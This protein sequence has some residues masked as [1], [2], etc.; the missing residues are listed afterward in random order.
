MGCRSTCS[1][2]RGGWEWLRQS[3]VAFWEVRTG[4]PAEPGLASPFLCRVQSK[5]IRMKIRAAVCPGVG[6]PAVRGL[7]VSLDAAGCWENRSEGRI[8]SGVGTLRCVQDGVCEIFSSLQGPRHSRRK[9]DSE[10]SSAEP[11]RLFSSRCVRTFLGGQGLRTMEQGLGL[12]RSLLSIYL[13]RFLS[14][15]CSKKGLE[16]M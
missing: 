2:P 12:A 1:C 6:T 8:R 7:A 13:A 11:S 5:L 9:R 10:A 4:G 16:P 3:R 14:E 15:S